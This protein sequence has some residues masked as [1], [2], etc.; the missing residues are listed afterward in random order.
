VDFNRL[1]FGL[2]YLHGIGVPGKIQSPRR[3]PAQGA[4]QYAIIGRPLFLAF[5]SSCVRGDLAAWSSL[6]L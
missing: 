6:G 2:E 4:A 5:Q 3:L 1:S